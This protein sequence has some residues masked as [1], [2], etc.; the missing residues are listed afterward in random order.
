MFWQQLPSDISNL[1]CFNTVLHQRISPRRRTSDKSAVLC[2]LP[3]NFETFLRWRISPFD[4]VS[5][6]LLRDSYNTL[7]HIIIQV[8]KTRLALCDSPLTKTKDKFCKSCT[9]QHRTVQHNFHTDM[10]L[11]VTEIVYQ[12]YCIPNREKYNKL[13]KV[14]QII[15]KLISEAVVLSAQS[16]ISLLCLKIQ[17]L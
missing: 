16:G 13:Y 6:H 10:E 3:S 9:K 1:Y 8:T 17:M 7:L 14:C 15:L 2:P 12:L 5:S 4:D 11:H